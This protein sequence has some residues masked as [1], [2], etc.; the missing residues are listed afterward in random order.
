MDMQECIRAIN[1]LF[2]RHEEDEAALL[3][4]AVGRNPLMVQKVISG[5]QTGVDRAG[6]D[7][8]LRA[9][10]PAGGS[11]PRGR[12]A[13]DGTIPEDYPLAELDSVSYQVRTRRNVVDSDGTLILTKGALTDGTLQ[14]FNYTVKYRKPCL[15]V[16]LDRS[17][18]TRQVFDWLE[19][20]RIAVL[21]IAGP[22]ESKYPEGVYKDANAFLEKVMNA[23]S[24][25]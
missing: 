17:P 5:G 19:T 12:K 15:V 10:I 11:C 21:N 9:G 1:R 20:H 3:E 22:R 16:N 2:N 18:D 7:A 13:E 4:R 14:T 25:A 24:P 6:L 23:F 8:A